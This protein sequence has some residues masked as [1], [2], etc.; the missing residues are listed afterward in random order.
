MKKDITNDVVFTCTFSTRSPMSLQMGLG[1]RGPTPNSSPAVQSPQGGFFSPAQS[2]PTFPV[3]QNNSQAQGQSPF[4]SEPSFKSPGGMMFNRQPDTSQGVSTSM[5]NSAPVDRFSSPHMGSG[6]GPNLPFG[7]NF[8]SMFRHP[9]PPS[10]FP[11]PPSFQAPPPDHNLQPNQTSNLHGD[12][13]QTR[14]VGMGG[15]N[16]F[17]GNQSTAHGNQ[18]NFSHAPGTERPQGERGSGQQQQFPPN[19]QM[20]F[21]QVNVANYFN[22]KM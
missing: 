20:P 5:Q 6:E 13:P 11:P 8:A 3:G 2:R 19:L 1:N 10:R 18:T 21:S 4:G 22:D 7:P 15:T 14:S 16:T 17:F 9:P 12:S